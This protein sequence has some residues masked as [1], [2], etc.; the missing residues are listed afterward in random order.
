MIQAPQG[1]AHR[2]VKLHREMVQEVR[3][4][5]KRVNSDEPEAPTD[6]AMLRGRKTVAR[7]D[8]GLRG[9]NLREACS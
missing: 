1:A 3:Q 9:K 6:E 8:A 5:K 7:N 2:L 4:R